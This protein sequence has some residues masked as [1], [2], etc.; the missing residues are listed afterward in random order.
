[1]CKLSYI[2]LHV[3]TT[4]SDGTLTPGE[5]V[6][7]AQKKGLTAIAITDHDTVW[8]IEEALAA[9]KKTG[10]EIVPGIELSVA[11]EKEMHILG[12]YIDYKN[13]FL[14]NKIKKLEQF[15]LQRNP[16]IIKKLNLLGLEI[17]LGEVEE[18][19]SGNIMGRPHIA[20]VMLKKGYVNTVND[21]FAKYLA[22]GKPAYVEKKRISIQEAIATIHSAGGC[23]VL[24]HPKYLGLSKEKLDLLLDELISYGLDGMEVY[25]G[26]HSLSEQICYKDLAVKKG[27]IMTGGSDFHGAS[28]PEIKLGQGINKARFNL[29]LLDSLKSFAIDKER[30]FS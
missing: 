25:Y 17:E 10:V 26:G 13:L 6:S 12:Y 11:Y 3:H 19:V 1:M 2:D 9:G 22:E 4:A 16:L 21:A 23:A 29:N 20:Q 18:I 8:G 5:V 14:Q 27:L 30:I 7:L 28:K 15:R 24:A